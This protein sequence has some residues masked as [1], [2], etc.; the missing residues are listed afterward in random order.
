[1]RGSNFE[2][3]VNLLVPSFMGSIFRWHLDYV[4]EELADFCSI[5]VADDF[6]VA[7]FAFC[8]NVIV[9]HKLFQ[10]AVLVLQKLVNV[11]LVW[12]HHVV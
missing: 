4:I 12:S 3:V 10:S 1:M 11:R 8:Q 5:K 7:P 9:R 2:F 6:L